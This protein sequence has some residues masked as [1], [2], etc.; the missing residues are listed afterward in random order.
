MVSTGTALSNVPRSTYKVP[1]M[2][3][4]AEVVQHE[5]KKHLKM[6]PSRQMHLVIE[7]S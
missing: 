3:A 6:H 7:P 2:Q 5:M 1:Y 4:S